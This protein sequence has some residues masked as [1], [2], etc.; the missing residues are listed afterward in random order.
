MVR[1]ADPFITLT[2]LFPN[3][4]Y[5]NLWTIDMKGRSNKDVIHIIPNSKSCLGVVSTLAPTSIKTTFRF[6]PGKIPA[7]AGFSAPFILPE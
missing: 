6:A 3:I 5:C 1:Y 7:K 4:Q 2:P